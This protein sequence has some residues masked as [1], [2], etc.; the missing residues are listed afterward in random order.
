MRL[1][2]Y[3]FGILSPYY[4]NRKRTL[5]NTYTLKNAER[6]AVY[7]LARLFAIYI[8]SC[9]KWKASHRSLI[10]REVLQKFI[11]IL[12]CMLCQLA[13]TL[14]DV[15]VR[16]VS[17]YFI[18]IAHCYYRYSRKTEMFNFSRRRTITSFHFTRTR[19]MLIFFV[20]LSLISSLHFFD[21]IQR[22]TWIWRCQII[23]SFLGCINTCIA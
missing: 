10:P 13:S 22:L 21:F 20:S 16:F 15:R 18:R 17:S 14:V 11:R 4:T 3:A 23:I 9:A 2:T 1:Q 8:R 6:W 5:E 12:C 7:I 19:F